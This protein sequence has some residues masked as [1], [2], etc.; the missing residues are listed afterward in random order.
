MQSSLILVNLIDN[1]GIVHHQNFTRNKNTTLLVA[2]VEKA[3]HYKVHDAKPCL[4]FNHKYS[5]I[6]LY[7]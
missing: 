7:S 6:Y 5:K 3:C 1:A 2:V 4:H